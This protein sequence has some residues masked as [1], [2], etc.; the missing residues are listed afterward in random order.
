M[1]DEN[2]IWGEKGIWQSSLVV[3]GCVAAVSAL[4]FLL[5]SVL[6]STYVKADV[7]RDNA[8][9]SCIQRH[10][11]RVSGS[12]IFAFRC[13]RLFCCIALLVLSVTG[14][15]SPPGIQ[16]AR[17][18]FQIGNFWLDLSLCGVYT[19]TVLLSLVSVLASQ[20]FSKLACVHLA[21]VLAATWGIYVYRDIWPLA[22]FTLDPI[23]AAE[24]WLLWTKFALLSVA[25]VLIP[26]AAPR[27]Y[28]PL[29]SENPREPNPEQTASIL[30]MALY[31]FMDPVIV[32]AHRAPHLKLDELPP[33]ADYDMTEPLIKKSYP[34][35]DPFELKK[36]RH[37][38]WG[39]LSVFYKEYMLLTVMLLV[40]VP[41]SLASPVG[42]NRL[43][44]YL[45]TGG[46]DA[47]VRPW[48]WIS[49]LFFGPVIGSITAEWYMFLG[50]RITVRAQAI[51]TSLVFDHALRIRVKAGSDNSAVTASGIS[52]PTALD[53]SSFLDS[54][55]ASH[56]SPDS[57][58]DTI[59]PKSIDSSTINKQ[60][61]EADCEGSSTSETSQ[62]L[63]GR[64]NTLVT[65]D[66]DKIT[67]ARDFVMLLVMVP[68]QAVLSLWFLYSVLGWSSFVGFATMLT[69]APLPGYI[70]SRTR[71][72]QAEKMKK[73]DARVQAV[74]E[75]MNVIRMIKLFG[76]ERRTADQI[77]G[78]R[79]EELIWLKKYNLMS[80]SINIMTFMIPLVTMLVTFSM[81]TLVMK[82]A[83]TASTIFS[84]MAAFD[85]LR[86]ILNHVT[87]MTPWIIQGKVSLDR[88]QDFLQK[89]EVLDRFASG[90]IEPTAPV[91]V[92]PEVI[93]IKEARFTWANDN[94]G[95]STPGCQ[96]RKFSLRIEDELI[97]KRG[98]INLILGPTGS[99][100]TSILMALLGE[101]H[102]IPLSHKSFVNLPRDKGV[103]YAA[104]ETWVQNDTIR[105]N[106][107]FGS[108][109]DEERYNK[110]IMQC[111]LKRDLSLFDAGDQA[112]VGERGLTLSGGQKARITL[113]RAI[114]SSAE[115]LL[116]DDVLAA[117]DVHTARWIMDKCLKGDLVRGRTII[118]V[119]HNVTLTSLTADFVVSLGTD[120]RI[121]SVGSLDVALAK[122]IKLL[123]ETQHEDQYSNTAVRDI[124]EL[125][126]DAPTRVSEDGKLVVE[127]EVAEGHVGWAAMKLY[128]TAL[129]GSRPLLF[130]LGSA[131]GVFLSNLMAAGQIWF[132][133]YWGRQ[134]EI[135]DD[136]REV[137]VGFYA[138]IY[139][140]LLLVLAAT[141]CF[142]WS[143][144]IIGSFRA[145]KKIH[146]E[147][148]TSI[149]GTTMRWLDQTPVSRVIT[150]CTQDIDAIDS[151]LMEY[152]FWFMEETLD[153][154]VRF[155]AVIA[156]SPIFSIP[157]AIIAGVG[158][159][160]G[161]IYMKAQLCV[162]REMS[163]A[164]AP[165]LGHFGAATAGLTSIRAYGAQEAF[166]QA[167]MRHI[168]R[169]TRAA[170]QFNNLNRWVI[171]RLDTLGGI[172]ATS[173][174]VYLIYGTN[175]PASSVG[176]SLNMAVSF[177]A[178]ILVWIR[179]LN[180][181]ELSGSSLERI[182]QYRE[183]EHEPQPTLAGVPPAYWPSS[184]GLKVD[185]LS[186]RYSADGPRILH[187]ISFEVRSGER[188]GIVGRT[189]S[190]KSSL[191]LA[192]LRCIITEGKVYYDGIPTDSVN[193]EAL[194]SHITIIPQVP[195]MLSGTLRQ[196]LDPFEQ[197]TD[198]VLNDALRAAGLF[199]LQSETDDGRITLDTQIANGGS[200]LS[201][202]QRQILALAR[203]V[204]QQS[205]LLILDEATSAIDYATD[206]VIQRSL[207]SGL[208]KDVTVLTVA[209]RLQTIM[210]SDR[211]LVL[212][213]GR[214]VEFDTPSELLKMGEG[215]LRAL[216][217]ES[218]DKE[219]LYKMAQEASA[220]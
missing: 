174:A 217:E 198:A 168:D 183:I 2:V 71:R 74:T 62:S 28:I 79:Q 216:V 98:H 42:I 147:L 191:T 97:F 136:P 116:L 69:L 188:V 197:D 133:G 158:A 202:G 165:V 18:D 14:A 112:E 85:L 68:L 170:V 57:E 151:T 110:V 82:Q 208:G 75:T 213:A 39:L 59:H 181:L 141:F 35:L 7:S 148:I 89:T 144:W 171:V 88:L 176:F 65:I 53:T 95:A 138:R 146:Q 94:D 195:E 118:L 10:I 194:R 163:N 182:Q 139:S 128:G 164:K 111:A 45:E 38:F 185:R 31:S 73:T 119:T 123:E 162:K 58:E 131:G 177:A 214:V 44:R 29:D 187:E 5:Q 77:A 126:L 33:I 17:L 30:S 63:V 145:S 113:A 61:S 86:E 54:S 104:Q 12:V 70:A 210:D 6:H 161:Q 207:R 219:T 72:I 143:T 200:N 142:S 220:T 49:W 106:I 179:I 93:G 56:S 117:L 96:R 155:C 134:Y 37:I 16:H 196:N 1:L 101:M 159:L 67:R 100:K 124:D 152:V 108:P 203:A 209:H 78:K 41:T 184:G 91:E 9:L 3:S 13:A 175:T 109:F 99:G 105:E 120:G 149:L 90:N 129:G 20:P 206:A 127:E 156:Y 157:G 84:S 137:H 25:G 160:C 173:L 19:Y 23:D 102:Y 34:C 150:R 205:K 186:A 15:A 180:T 169:Y 51:I 40:R 32:K 193:L 135:H 122:N 199:S 167:S 27:Q 115:I 103:A 66:V 24:G 43:L 211:I 8:D 46:E 204:V 76:W 36:D 22:T 166:R 48:V 178:M 60:I 11:E 114:Y 189:G 83:L 21:I 87:F 212:D 50:T 81:Y 55:T 218:G 192:L 26:L 132:L 153:M 80:L 130:W 4:L 154:L 64:L 107:L 190:G 125:I 92:A 172:F 215:I 201:V 52:A 121:A 47:I 140:L